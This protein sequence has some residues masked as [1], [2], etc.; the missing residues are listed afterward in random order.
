[1]AFFCLESFLNFICI[2]I[3]HLKKKPRNILILTH[4]HD[5]LGRIVGLHGWII[6]KQTKSSFTFLGGRGV[7]KQFCFHCIIRGKLSVLRC[8]TLLITGSNPTDI[9]R[10]ECHTGSEILHIFDKI[11]QT[12]YIHATSPLLW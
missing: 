11:S 2:I 3:G 5:L 12:Q 10:F 6:P 7:K 4:A 1:M 9:N 8:Y